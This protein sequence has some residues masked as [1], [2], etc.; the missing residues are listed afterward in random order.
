MRLLTH[1]MLQSHIKGVTNG[2]PFKIEVAKVAT[3]EADF[4][5]GIP[6]TCSTEKNTTKS[7]QPENIFQH[8]QNSS[9]PLSSAQ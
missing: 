2:Y 7:S 8:I 4:N 5:K 6:N 1:N 9:A 3:K